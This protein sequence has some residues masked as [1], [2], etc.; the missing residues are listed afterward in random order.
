M[1]RW[2]TSVTCY[3]FR[4]P[5]SWGP[6]ASDM[7]AH[8]RPGVEAWVPTSRL[9]LAV[10]DEMRSHM[11]VCAVELNV[12]RAEIAWDGANWV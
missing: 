7:S 8:S 2:A 1:R 5:V 9:E 10:R 12:D 4:A 6:R 3:F 11:R